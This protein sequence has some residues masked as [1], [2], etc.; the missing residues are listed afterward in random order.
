MVAFT[1]R[2]NVGKS[3]LINNLVG[4]KKLART[5]STPGRTQVINF[6][7]VEDKWIFVDLPGYGFAKVAKQEKARW[8]PM[9]EEF[10]TEDRRLK[11]VVMIIDA[12]REPTAIDL[13]MKE[14][15]DECG[16]PHLVVATKADK[17]SSR[18][19]QK[20][21]IPIQDAFSCRVIPY[22]AATGMG[23]QGLWQVF[24]RI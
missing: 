17:L 14:W 10:L 2:S 20:S 24:K 21:V 1:G 6:F 9:V 22:S 15:L 4:R 5:S 7:K 13:V 18:Q 19:L 12:R 3:S 11:L 23:K 8:G 16:I